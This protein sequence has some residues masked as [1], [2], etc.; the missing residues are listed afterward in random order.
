[1]V[2]NINRPYLR[3]QLEFHSVF[4]FTERGFF[5]ICQ[6]QRSHLNDCLHCN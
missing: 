6:T 5:H 2:G 3:S 1:M 4:Y